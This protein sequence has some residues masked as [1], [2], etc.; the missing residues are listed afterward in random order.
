MKGG[1]FCLRKQSDFFSS[2]KYIV[3]IFEQNQIDLKRWHRL[4]LRIFANNS[5]SLWNLDEICL[6]SSEM[7]YL[8]IEFV[9]QIVKIKYQRFYPTYSLLAVNF[10]S[11]IST[12]ATSF[13]LVY[14]NTYEKIK[15]EKWNAMRKKN[16]FSLSQTRFGQIEWIIIYLLS[17]VFSVVLFVCLFFLS[18]SLFIYA[19][20]AHK[21]VLFADFR[22]W[23]SSKIARKRDKR[24]IFRPTDGNFDF[25][26]RSRRPA[27]TTIPHG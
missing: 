23:L 17:F 26:F 13:E 1:I 12:C 19:T 24:R 5:D 25:F 22:N 11:E 27:H 20:L 18:V 7:F 9:R 10:K 2:C 15:F 21:L 14:K 6:F 8:L 3:I 16:Q 4:K